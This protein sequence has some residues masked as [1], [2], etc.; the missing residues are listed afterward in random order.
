MNAKHLI[1]AIGMAALV[2]ANAFSLNYTNPAAPEFPILA[3]YSILPDSAQTPQRYNELREAGFNISFSHFKTDE[4]VAAALEAS[5][6][7]GV[8]IMVTSGPLYS[9]TANTVSRFK[10]DPGVAGWFLR[11]EP[12]A[13]G[14]RD[15]SDFRDRI[16]ASDSTH[17]L[18]L[19]LFPVMVSAET[20]GTRDYE[21][22]V[23]RFVDEVRLPLISYDFY[24]IVRDDSTGT[25]YPREDHFENLE[26]VRRVSIR[27]NVPFW[28]FCLSTAHHPY[29]VPNSVHMRYEA[30]TALAYGA[31]AI[32]YFTYWQPVSKQWDFHHAPID[33]TGKRTD[34]YY[35][36][37]DLNREIQALAPV[38]LGAVID[39]VAFISDNLP[40]GT[41][42][43][44]SQP[45]GF[46]P[47]TSDGPGV[48]VS[49]LHN[50]HRHYLMLV[51]RDIDHAQHISMRRP[52]GTFRILSDGTSV[53]DNPADDIILAPGDY[54]LIQ[55]R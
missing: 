9:E 51:N 11:D 31:Q 29:P 17:L 23:Q 41:H 27:N 13:S 6:N 18:Y 14:F 44:S 33:E 34:I 12:L 53:A 37:K 10:D 45:D 42:Y 54:C 48:L 30:F 21:D 52:Y 7:S 2:Y 35:L 19:N 4:Q 26:I 16:V 36:I 49:Q 20:L 24:P 47:I 3:W 32:Q 8:K 15:L 25:V 43:V 40:K 50:G 55:Y 38:F 5:K 1:S 22:Y 39:D 46:G 28:A